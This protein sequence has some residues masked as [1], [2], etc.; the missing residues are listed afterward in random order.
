MLYAGNCEPVIARNTKS[1]LDIAAR[2]TLQVFKPD[3]FFLLQSGKALNSFTSDLTYRSPMIF[4]VK[5]LEKRFI[6]H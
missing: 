2:I 5:E 4:G 3:K 1:I 6:N